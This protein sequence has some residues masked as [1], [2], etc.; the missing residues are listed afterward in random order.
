MH[1]QMV[2]LITNLNFPWVVPRLPGSLKGKLTCR[3]S[4]K[5]PKSFLFMYVRSGPITLASWVS[6]EKPC[7][8]TWNAV[9][10][11]FPATGGWAL[12]EPILATLEEQD[13]Y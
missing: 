1:P 6:E 7:T 3:S 10:S 13:V 11:C 4:V 2:M 8:I 12:P 5:T 9:P